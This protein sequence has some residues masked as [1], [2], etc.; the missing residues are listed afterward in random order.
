MRGQAYHPLL[1][2][3]MS[4]ACDYVKWTQAVLQ[5]G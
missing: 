3:H 4:G 5:V 1:R 2:M